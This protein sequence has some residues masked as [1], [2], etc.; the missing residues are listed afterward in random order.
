MGDELCV[1][2]ASLGGVVTHRC[3]YVPHVVIMAQNMWWTIG[4]AIARQVARTVS[5]IDFAAWLAPKPVPFEE[6]DDSQRSLAVTHTFPQVVPGDHVPP[7][8]VFAEPSDSIVQL[9]HAA[10]YVTPEFIML[11]SIIG[12]ISV[13]VLS[14]CCVCKCSRW[15]RSGSFCP[16]ARRNPSPLA[17][18]E[19]LSDMA[20]HYY[21]VVQAQ[22]PGLLE[23]VPPNN[24]RNRRNNSRR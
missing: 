22:N 20:L 10:T 7:L 3:H 12:L 21:T 23:V 6:I 2:C 1:F 19:Q 14:V 18:P 4:A 13:I 24:P 15:M 11:M 8:V 17:V 5:E 9:L 16:C